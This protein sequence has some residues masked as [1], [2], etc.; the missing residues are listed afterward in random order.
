MTPQGKAE[1]LGEDKGLVGQETAGK[2]QVSGERS[3]ED[4]A[5]VA[6]GGR[7]RPVGADGTH[8]YPPDDASKCQSS[9]APL[10]TIS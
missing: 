1:Q 4:L 7:V 6:G 3:L 10:R 2:D 8:H 9:L 5:N